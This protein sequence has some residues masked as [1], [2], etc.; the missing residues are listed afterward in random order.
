MG[1]DIAADG[2]DKGAS[3]GLGQLHSLAFQPRG[4]SGHSWFRRTRFA[5]ALFSPFGMMSVVG[6]AKDIYLEK[7]GLDATM[8]SMLVTVASFW[9][10][11]QDMLLGRLQDKETLRF[12]PVQRWGRRAPWLL[13]H[14][15]LAALGASLMYLPPEGA[16]AYV[17][18][19]AMW[20]ITCWGI[21]G[22]IIAFEAARQQ[23][24]PFKEERISV[25]GLCKYACMA[26]G[27][28]GGLVFLVLSGDASFTVRLAFVLYIV[29]VGL[30]SLQAVPLFKEARPRNDEHKV[31]TWWLRLDTKE[32][33][34]VIQ[35]DD[36]DLDEVRPQKS[37]KREGHTSPA[38]GDRGPVTLSDLRALLHEQSQQLQESQ[39]RQLR[40]AIRDLQKSTGAQ[41]EAIQTDIHRHNDY[42]DQLRDQGERVEARLQALEAGGSGLATMGADKNNDTRKNLMIFGGWG[43]DTHRDT[44][45]TELRELLGKIGALQYFDDIFTTGPRRGNA[46]GL[47]T[48]RQEETEGDLKRKM[49]KIAQAV[50]EANLRSEHMQSDKNLWAS[51]SKS[52]L[53]RMRSSHAGKL[54]RM[55]MEID[56][57]LRD[58]MDVEWNAGSLWLRGVLLGHGLTSPQPPELLDAPKVTSV[59][60]GLQMQ[61]LKFTMGPISGPLGPTARCCQIQAGWQTTKVDER[62][63]LVQFRDDLRQWRGNGILFVELW[64][65][66]ARF[67]TGVTD[68]VTAEEEVE[69][70]EATSAPPQVKTSGTPPPA[71]PVEQGPEGGDHD[72]LSLTVEI[73]GKGVDQEILMKLA[74]EH[75]KPK[76]G[77]R[78]QD[79][80]EV[81]QLYREAKRHGGEDR[82]KAAHKARRQAHDQWSRD[83]LARASQRSWK[84]YKDLK[85]QQSGTTWSVHMS[86]EAFAAG[87]DPQEWT[88][89]HFKALFTDASGKALPTWN[90]G[91]ADSNPFSMEELELAVQNGK[92]GKAVGID[93]TSSELVKSLMQ[94]DQTACA[95]LQWM[96]NIRQGQPIPPQWL[97]TIVTLLPKI[98][99]PNGPGDL[100]P[101]SLGSAIGKVFG[102]M[103]LRRTREAIQPIGPEQCS[104]SGRQTADYVYTAIRSFQL[105]TEWR[106]GLHWVKLDI[107]KAFDSLDRARALTHLQKALPESMHLEF[108]SWRRLLLPGTATIRTPWG[109]QSIGQTRGI[110]QGAVESP[111]LFSLAMELALSE[112]Q[113]HKEWPSTIGAAPDLG[114]SDLLFMDDSLLWAGSQRDLKRKYALLSR[115]LATWGLMVNP[116]KTAYY[117]SPH[118]TERGALIL[119][120]VPVESR[121]SLEVMG[122]AL[123]VPL[124]PAGLMDAALAKARK[125]YFA[126]RDMLECRTPL[127]ERLKLFSSTVAG[128]GLWYAAAVPPSPQGMGAVNSLQLELVARM[129]GFR[130][131]SNE[132]WLDYHTRSRRAARQ[133]LVNHQSPRWSTIWLQ[134]YWRYKGHIA[135]AADRAQPPASSLID[136]F[137]TYPWWKQQQRMASGLRHP[138]SFYP[139]LSNDELRLN[140][141]AA[142]E[143]WRQLAKD[144][145]AW[146]QAEAE[147]IRREDV[148]WTTGGRMNPCLGDMP[149]VSPS[150]NM[151][152]LFVTNML[153]VLYV[154]QGG[155]RWTQE[156]MKFEAVICEPTL[157][158]QYGEYHCDPPHYTIADEKPDLNTHP[159][160][161]LY[162]LPFLSDQ[163][164]QDAEFREMPGPPDPSNYESGHEQDCLSENQKDRPYQNTY[165]A[166]QQQMR[167]LICETRRDHP[168]PHAE[169]KGNYKNA[170]N[171]NKLRGPSADEVIFLGMYKYIVHAGIAATAFHDVLDDP[172]TP[173]WFR[174]AAE[175]GYEMIS[176]GADAETLADSLDETALQREGEDWLHRSEKYRSG[177]RRLW[178][179]EKYKLER[180]HGPMQ[181]D[182]NTQREIPEF[183]NNLVD[184]I[185]RCMLAQQFNEL[186][187]YPPCWG[188]DA[189]EQANRGHWGA[190]EDDG[191]STASSSCTSTH[192]SPSEDVARARSRSRTPTRPT[193][194]SA[195]AEEKGDEEVNEDTELTNLVQKKWLLK[196][197][198]PKSQYQ[199]AKMIWQSA[200]PEYRTTST[201]TLD[202]TAPRSLLTRRCPSAPWHRTDE[203]M[204]TEE[205]VVEVT[206]EDT[207]GTS[208]AASSGTAA[209]VAE[210]PEADSAEGL[211]MILLGLDP[212]GGSLGVPADLNT[213][214]MT[215]PTEIVENVRATLAEHTAEEV[216]EMRDALP[217]VLT[218]IR[219]ELM[220][221]VEEAA[222]EH[223]SSSR[224]TPLETEPAEATTEG[225]ESQLMQRTV[226]GMLRTSKTGQGIREDKVALHHELQA[227][228]QGTASTLAR[229]LRQRLE[230]EMHY[231]E[232]WVT[233]E[234]VLAANSESKA[235]CPEGEEQA[236]HDEWIQ[237]WLKRLAKPRPGQSASSTDTAPLS[238]AALNDTQLYEERAQEEE[239]QERA[240]RALY[241]WHQQQ[242]AAEQAKLDDEVTLQ[243]HLGMSTRRPAKKVRLTVEIARDGTTHYSEFEVNEGEQIKLGISISEG[244]PGHY[245]GGRP[246]STADARE[247]LQKEEN[248]L[249]GERAEPP[250]TSY[251]MDDPDTR[252]LYEQWSTGQVTSKQVEEQGGR[253]LVAFYEAIREIESMHT[254]PDTYRAWLAGTLG[255]DMVKLRFGNAAMAL[256]RRLLELGFR[257][258]PSPIECGSDSNSSDPETVPFQPAPPAGQVEP[259]ACPDDAD[260]LVLGE[261]SETGAT[262]KRAA[263]ASLL[264]LLAEGVADGALQHL[265]AMKFWNGAYGVC[266]SS[267]LLYYVTYV[268][269]LSSWQRVQVI[270]GA[271][272]AAGV[273]E[274]VMNLVY[275]HLFTRDDSLRDM[276][277][278]SDRRLL[279]IVVSFRL[280]NACLTFIL[281]G[282]LEPSVFLL[283]VWSVITRMGLCSFSF[284]RI[285][286]QC[287]LVDEDCMSRCVDGKSRQNKREGQIFG[288]LSMSQI[289]AAAIF[290]SLTF[291]GLGLAGLETENCEASCS[292][293]GSDG[294]STCIDDC[295]R[296]V[297]DRQPESLRAYVRFV[298]GFF[299]PLCELL[300]A[301]HAYKFPIKNA[302]LRKLYLTKA[303]ERGDMGLTETNEATSVDAYSAKSQIVL[304][305]KAT[306][307]SVEMDSRWG[308]FLD[309]KEVQSMPMASAEDPAEPASAPREADDATRHSRTTPHLLLLG[310]PGTGKSQLLQAAQELGGRSIRTSGLGC[311]SAGLTCA[312]VRDGPDWALEAGALVLADGGVCCIDEFS[313]IRSHDKAAIHEAM[314]QQTVSVAKAGMICRLH[315]RCSVV[316]AQNCRGSSGKGRGQGAAYDLSS[317]LAVNSGL[318]PPLLSRFDLVV[319]FAEG[320][321][322]GATESDKAEFILESTGQSSVEKPPLWDHGRLREYLMWA[323]DKLLDEDDEPGAALL[324]ETYFQKLR[325]TSLNSGGG[326]GG[327]TA[328]TLES[329][330]RLAQAHAKL[331]GRRSVWIE[332]AVAVVVL[333]RASLQDHVVGAESL[334]S[335]EDFAPSLRDWQDET[336]ACGVKVSLEGLELHHGTEIPNQD[337]YL[338]LEQAILRS[339]K[340]CRSSNDKRLLVPLQQAM[341]IADAPRPLRAREPRGEASPAKALGSFCFLVGLPASHAVHTGDSSGTSGASEAAGEATRVPSAVRSGFKFGVAESGKFSE[342]APAAKGFRAAVLEVAKQTEVVVADAYEVDNTGIMRKW[343]IQNDNW[344]LDIWTPD[345]KRFQYTSSAG[346]EPALTISAEWAAWLD[347]GAQGG[348][349]A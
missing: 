98:P 177:L 201:R 64:V 175:L 165:F 24:Y 260:T 130:R 169:K 332:D 145:K 1:K 318:P 158:E 97:H 228:P 79:P 218:A 276:A 99:A 283:F 261:S 144:P 31:R 116:K 76:P 281:I 315:S 162:L 346:K 193:S 324:L 205:V 50:R 21:G 340:L 232:D 25:E 299:A 256:Y 134:R 35:S 210:G 344:N 106:W 329:L 28:A 40:S 167:M 333:H 291:L 194:A 298:I 117:A 290:S 83:K 235:T 19:L 45:L 297:I 170:Y 204:E 220:G 102:T 247:H 94:D 181:V 82:W 58:H 13:T 212:F 77:A 263:L 89:S 184:Y 26:G 107:S 48:Q 236:A 14:S 149:T 51:L 251:N 206:D 66:S 331:M 302:R 264:P 241:D 183:I 7:F 326:G 270:V 289:L 321:K 280:V 8:F 319:V 111:W 337:V 65:G 147:W 345:K 336:A 222:R 305:D 317:S 121:T 233:I 153:V 286:A 310:D 307:N 62:Y 349:P 303:A 335:G 312:A 239:A 30:L 269:H 154:S 96:E 109:E 306:S 246:V 275:V 265:L 313:T 135:R 87:R 112:A 334:P 128:A 152:Q 343:S 92:K 316:A 213:M 32:L 110:R 214:P 59:T 114:I 11:V 163:V 338:Y 271:G 5:L 166:F 243:A 52:K 211:W 288:A 258:V 296:H 253:D 273:T 3:C 85:Q 328:R 60:V 142:Q 217:N 23:I 231:V 242:R 56:P 15:F 301:Y 55:L 90:R 245:L 81:K 93:L 125:K 91:R 150:M 88:I 141:A 9:T 44:L 266:I 78:Y 119:D 63:T 274:A 12:F 176:R 202:P 2:P 108:D 192:S 208:G 41:I 80:P 348:Y 61:V 143:D 22:C 255:D 287:W 132:S 86:E 227:F 295:F 16:A 113:A 155:S 330:V 159:G 146:Q 71:D 199:T 347:A 138:A 223:S 20:M 151:V 156:D 191:A 67:S 124:K 172:G 127:K 10:P 27:G 272:T 197:R 221:L 185:R 259:D 182:Q 46:L 49:I 53:E 123:S 234:A 229:R 244:A 195:V 34:G 157:D 327:V 84:D 18:F 187:Y 279:R 39:E 226:T 207:G 196:A 285:S 277:G 74:R 314:E 224:P 105:D 278:K 267:M 190:N 250:R 148:A 292:V 268:L 139:Y 33:P 136:G 38:A 262:S 325:S 173:G 309:G 164:P 293:G 57:A 42:I 304:L 249:R 209:G 311:T 126:S 120:Q 203:E 186:Q 308:R 17:W 339:L 323:K 168:I 6:T 118:A 215:L 230:A 320:G 254:L 75:T 171:V 104:H 294:V 137:R 257:R 73:A 219:E 200:R 100:R 131:Q 341:A 101:I 189:Y 70:Q 216:E 342:A 140:R 284:W 29:P 43:P 225:D 95:L 54:K 188:H 115:S 133:I 103:I 36:S 68:D 72:R 240:D 69:G 180:E 238:H 322:G 47:V 178:A 179:R 282:V 252:A 237:K 160:L 174:T 198:R 4:P 37:N 248:R 161:E 300:I 129:A 122:V